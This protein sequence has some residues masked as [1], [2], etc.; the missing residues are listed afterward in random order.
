MKNIKNWVSLLFIGAVGGH[1]YAQGAGG[2]FGHTYTQKLEINE[3]RET[4][5]RGIGGGG[6]GWISERVALGG[7]LSAAPIVVNRK[8]SDLD[9]D[10][11][12]EESKDD[13]VEFEYSGSIALG[14]LTTDIAL[15]KGESLQVTVGGLFG[16]LSYNLTRKT[17]TTKDE[18]TKEEEKRLRNETEFVAVPTFITRFIVAPPL[19]IE[20]KYRHV[21][22]KLE[23]DGG[24]NVSLGFYFGRW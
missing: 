14:G 5:L 12:K 21:P 6:F 9:E 1:L 2:F 24:P 22:P 17:F 8:V 10:I 18:E 3:E 7:E 4:D 16:V 19:A 15:I 20:V 11:A 23:F 13:K